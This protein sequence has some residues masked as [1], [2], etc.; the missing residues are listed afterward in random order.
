M[1]DKNVVTRIV[2]EWLEGKDYF[3]VDITVSPDD[4]IVVEIDHAEGVW[5]DDCVEL[6]RYI[7]SKLNREEEDY[8][9]EVGS[10]GIGQPFKV[11]KQY[12]IHIGTDVEVLAKDGKKYVG[13]LSDANEENFTITVETKIKPEGAKRPKLVEQDI[14]FTYEEIKYT[15]YLISF[16]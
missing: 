14:T 7:E 11:L 10:A 8:E 1:I 2:N 5:I 16:K 15:K 4:K 12:L 13:V 9:L 6:S 3:L